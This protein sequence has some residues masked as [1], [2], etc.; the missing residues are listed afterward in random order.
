LHVVLQAETPQSLTKDQ[1]KALEALQKLESEKTYP[2]RTKQA[3]LAA[4]FAK[5]RAEMKASK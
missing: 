2:D 1:I 5:K 3:K 4:A